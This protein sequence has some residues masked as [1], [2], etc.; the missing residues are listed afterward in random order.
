MLDFFPELFL[1]GRPLPLLSLHIPL[2]VCQ[3]SPQLAIFPAYSLELPAELFVDSSGC[4]LLEQQLQYFVLVGVHLVLAAGANGGEGVDVLLDVLQLS[5][6]VH[7]NSNEQ[8]IIAM[9]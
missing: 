6:T 9:L 7:D 3:L 4:F 1:S 8:M 2:P 5:R